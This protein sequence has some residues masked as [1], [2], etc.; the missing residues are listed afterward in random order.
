MPRGP[1][2]LPAA[3][4]VSRS[5]NCNCRGPFDEFCAAE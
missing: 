2:A 5:V 3:G 4:Q 1:L